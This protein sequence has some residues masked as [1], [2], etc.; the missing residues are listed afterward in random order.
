M[1]KK[2]KKKKPA[3]F[4]RVLL[5]YEKDKDQ[6]EVD[7][8]P[9]LPGTSTFALLLVL[10]QSKVLSESKDIFVIIEYNSKEK[11]VSIKEVVKRPG[12]TK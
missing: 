2:N 9:E 6:M 4:Y 1:F 10:P 11:T 5:A 3:V 7:D 8:A 12:V